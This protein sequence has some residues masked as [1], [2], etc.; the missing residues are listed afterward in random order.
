MRISTNYND[1]KKP[2]TSD[3]VNKIVLPN[4]SNV[5]FLSYFIPAEWKFE[6]LQKIFP[7]LANNWKL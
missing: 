1:D 3:N 5:K 6:N 2:T 4:R 7:R